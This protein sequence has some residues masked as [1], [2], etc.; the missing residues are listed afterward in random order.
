MES[1]KTV[2]RGLA[3]GAG[4]A[5]VILG[6]ASAASADHL[7]VAEKVTFCHAAP[8]DNVNQYIE[9][10]TDDNGVGPLGEGQG[11]HAD[12]HDDD[13]I[14][15]F[16]YIDSEGNPADYPGKNLNNQE[17]LD[18]AAEDGCVPSVV[19]PPP[20]T[21]TAPPSTTAPPT[22]TGP[23]TTPARPIPSGGVDTGGTG[24]AGDGFNA[25]ASF[26]VLGGL[27]LAGGTA[28]IVRRRK[29]NG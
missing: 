12:E 29:Y 3:I 15:A 27:L 2:V 14:P 16:G 19:N 25:P 5:V 6:G 28:V 23:S 8:P 26:A 18:L 24:V 9:L 7:P 17:L 4:A 22:T 10:T 21:T 20:P 13:I 11:G 1:T